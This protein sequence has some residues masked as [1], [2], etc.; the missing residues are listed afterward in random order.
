M[1]DLPKTQALRPE[2]SSLTDWI[3]FKHPKGVQATYL[4]SHPLRTK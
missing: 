2:I 3:S 1:F 4:G